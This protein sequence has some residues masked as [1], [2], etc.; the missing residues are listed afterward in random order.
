MPDYIW[1]A[2]A[3]F[4]LAGTIKGTVGIGL[5]TAAI[6]ILGQFVEPRLA[7]TITILPI[8]ATNLWQIATSGAI[9]DTLKRYWLM[10]ITLIGF[11]LLM[12]QF[13]ATLSN[14]VLAI[15]VGVMVVAFA[16]INLAG[17]LPKL[18]ERFDTIG[19]AIAGTVSGIMG[20]LTGL[21]GP[22][23]FAYFLARHTDKNEFVGAI[24]VLLFIGGI[25]MAIGYWSAGLLNTT[26]APIAALLIVP[27]LI[28]FGLGAQIRKRLHADRFRTVL[29]VIFLLM[30]L[31]LIRR[32]LF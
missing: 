28:G 13:V 21:W 26:T 3:A 31:N 29:L 14:D 20:G 2:L 9:V 27:S 32:A 22:P 12:S 19:Q 25:P 6:G 8:I 24:G 11:M 18:P 7:I 30:G 16:A 1:I 17:V 5:P 10:A 23:L 15:L 4:L